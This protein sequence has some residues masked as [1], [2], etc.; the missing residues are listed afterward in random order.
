MKATSH[1]LVALTSPGN[2]GLSW[3][4]NVFQ[5]SQPAQKAPMPTGTSTSRWTPTL[6]IATIAAVA[7]T[8]ARPVW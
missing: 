6:I 2:S 7:T 1:S 4:V 5:P 3:P 8:S